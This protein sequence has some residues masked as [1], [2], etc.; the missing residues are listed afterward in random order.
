MPQIPLRMDTVSPQTVTQQLLWHFNSEEPAT[1]KYLFHSEP[2]LTMRTPSLNFIELKLHYHLFF[3]SLKPQ[4]MSILYPMLKSMSSAVY[5]T[6][7]LPA[8]PSA[9]TFYSDVLQVRCGVQNRS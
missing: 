3:W 2:L 4:Q 5:H 6:A 9:R 1:S 7:L 8:P